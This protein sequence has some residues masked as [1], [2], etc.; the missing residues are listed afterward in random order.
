MEAIK[1]YEGYDSATYLRP[2]V[3]SGID[4][5][6]FYVTDKD[7]PNKN[8]YFSFYN[9]ILQDFLMANGENLI[10][11]IDTARTINQSTLVVLQQI[12]GIYKLQTAYITITH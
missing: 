3:A 4:G 8:Y 2:S 10:V 9:T 11:R 7:N 1:T 6:V 5:G 12:E